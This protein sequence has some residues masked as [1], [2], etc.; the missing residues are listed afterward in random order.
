MNG[1]VIGDRGRTEL[2]TAA[3]QEAFHGVA[4]RW[5]KFSRTVPC[6]I[7]TGLPGVAP[8]FAPYWNGVFKF[9]TGTSTSAGANTLT[10][11][12]SPGW[13]VDTLTGRRVVIT[14]G[15]G[16][17]Q[18]RYIAS[19]TADTI[20]VTEDWSTPPTAS[21]F[22]VR[23]AWVVYWHGDSTDPSMIFTPIVPNTNGDNWY[24][25]GG[26]V[27]PC[28]ML[29]QCLWEMYPN[30][31]WFHFIK[32]A[33]A[34]PDTG[35]MNTAWLSYYMQEFA[36][37][38]AAATQDGDVLDVQYIIIDSSLEDIVSGN[39]D[40]Q[41]DL[42]ALIANIR[43]SFGPD[44]L[45]GIVS[46][47]S[48]VYST[49]S[50]SG[51]TYAR[52][53]NKYV[54]ATHD[55]VV[56][57]DMQWAHPGAATAM[58]AFVPSDW[59]YYRLQ[60]YVEAGVRW[61][62]IWA[63]WSANEPTADPGTPL[64]VVAMVT[65]SQGSTIDPFHAVLSMQESIIGSSPGYIRAG[66]YI[67]N[68]QT[69][70]VELYYAVTNST[71]LP[72][73]PATPGTMGP[74]VTM[75]KALH[76]HWTNGVL[77]FKFSKSGATISDEAWKAGAAGSYDPASNDLLPAL[78]AAWNDCCASV[79]RDLGRRA[80]CVGLLLMIGDNDCITDATAAA[81][82]TKLPVVLDALRDILTT[83]SDGPAL[84]TVLMQIPK[85]V[86]TP[87]SPRGQSTHLVASARET[88]RAA[89]LQLAEDDD[90]VRVIE[91]SPT[92]HEVERGASRIHYGAEAAY[93]IGYD[94]SE[95]LIELN[96]PAVL[97]T[98]TVAADEAVGESA[99]AALTAAIDEAPDVASYTQP[100]GLS[101]TRRSVDDLLKLES[102]RQ[103][104]EARA[105]GFRRS[106]VEFDA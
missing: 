55:N 81:G 95:L 27:T 15:V 44:P 58:V 100:D 62:A 82:A 63:A 72:E 30:A 8:Q 49:T 104:R 106:R 1:G 103:T 102:A 88:M 46:H 34:G 32:L 83:R 4:M 39:V 36:C 89:A 71:T 79:I 90:R 94:A 9:K 37:A 25:F 21:G 11:A 35:I 73:V 85:H 24:E 96:D 2:S 42:I 3:Y 84:G 60:D 105:S 59:K 12:P 40:Y 97:N 28:T 20:T 18:I 48:E 43:A 50:P 65:D 91:W 101:V 77:V 22:E 52:S 99:S 93:R 29:M 80:D 56:V 61:T 38:Q 64:S 70:M 51:A 78:E 45:I 5:P 53:V 17:G 67:Y 41:T 87:G 66:E 6:E 98:S 23:G 54:A 74:E 10:V 26:G 14:S 16:D 86:S 92:L 19:N 33:G 75:L 31:P 57:L 47:H 68:G 7:A 69:Y 76:E 13:G